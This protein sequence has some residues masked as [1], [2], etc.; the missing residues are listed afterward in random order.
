ML[1]KLNI[2]VLPELPICSVFKK[3]FC[4]CYN[5]KINKIVILLLFWVLV[6]NF[7]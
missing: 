5:S 3:I 7:I 6:L 4:P 2:V 1:E